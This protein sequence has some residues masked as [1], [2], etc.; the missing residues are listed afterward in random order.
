MNVIRILLRSR[1]PRN[2][3]FSMEIYLG[4]YRYE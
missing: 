4:A 1:T 3:N 2:N